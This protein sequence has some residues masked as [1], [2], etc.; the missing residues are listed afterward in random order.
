MKINTFINILKQK[1]NTMIIIYD[2]I[3]PFKFKKPNKNLVFS[4]KK[5]CFLA[6]VIIINN[7]WKCHYLRHNE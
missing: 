1:Q 6:F 4:L 3:H 2:E 5:W 7:K